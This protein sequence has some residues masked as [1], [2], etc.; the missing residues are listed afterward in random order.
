MF[1]LY[2]SGF[3]LVS[4]LCNTGWILILQ[5]RFPFVFPHCKDVDKGVSYFW[6]AYR[7]TPSITMSEPILKQMFNFLCVNSLPRPIWI[8]HT[9]LRSPGK[10][11]M[12]V[13][14]YSENFFSILGIQFSYEHSNFR[15]IFKF[16]FWSHFSISLALFLAKGVWVKSHG[17]SKKDLR[18]LG[19]WNECLHACKNCLNLL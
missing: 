17:W 15:F 14:L 7:V 3:S 16:N 4:A 10:V 9:F 13:N 8:S 2:S 18:L 11:T 6:T 12:F 19:Y 5:E 1:L